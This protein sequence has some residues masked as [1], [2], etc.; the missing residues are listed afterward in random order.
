MTA[1]GC[2]SV[3]TLTPYF[4][5]STGRNITQNSMSETHDALSKGGQLLPGDVVVDKIDHERRV[6]T[7]YHRMSASRVDAVWDDP[8]NHEVIDIG[9]DDAVVETVP[10]PEP[11]TVSVPETVTLLPTERLMRIPFEAADNS[12]RTQRV[13]VRSVFAH[14]L[15][16]MRNTDR[17]GLAEAIEGQLR[18]MF[19]RQYAEDI[20]ALSGAIDTTVARDE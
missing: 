19:D 12:E 9:P 15:A 6:V 17:A 5:L 20:I 8:V 16:D 14:M 18:R 11:D 1:P 10:L 4:L 7:G 13:V 3:I 2:V